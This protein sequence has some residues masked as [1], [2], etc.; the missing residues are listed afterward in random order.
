MKQRIITACWLIPLAVLWMF[1]TSSVIFTIGAVIL[2]LLGAWEW[3]KFVC[4]KYCGIYTL[5]IA[6][7]IGISSYFFNPF[8]S[9]V[10]THIYSAPAVVG[11]LGMGTAWWIIATL[12][13]LKYPF[14]KPLLESPIVT[15]ILGITTLLPFFWSLIYLHEAHYPVSLLP[16]DS[17][18]ANLFFVMLLVWCAD[19]GAYFTGKFCGKHKMIPNVSPNKTI[20][21]LAGGIVLSL[22]VA[23]GATFMMDHWNAISLVVAVIFAV[24]ASVIGDLSES[25]FKRIAGI[26][27]SSNLLPG[28]GGVLD[29][30]DSLTAALPVYAFIMYLFTRLA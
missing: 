6:L 1:A 17:G 18:S 9:D 8:S 3:G 19:S 12:L 27:D 26:K 22:L 30:V 16:F 24:V 25:M 28:H 4:P 11:I 23:F 14:D 2:V 20:E 29:R 5:P 15:F 13:V 10:A 21:G 7:G